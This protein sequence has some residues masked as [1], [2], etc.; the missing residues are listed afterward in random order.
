MTTVAALA[1]SLRIRPD[2]PDTTNL[3]EAPVRFGTKAVV[4]I[5]RLKE[6]ELATNHELR[7][8]HKS[9][10]TISR[11]LHIEPITRFVVP[12][13]CRGWPGCVLLIGWVR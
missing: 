2:L 13:N 4:V 12:R 10:G 1:E 6:W 11:F 9:P 7:N 5:P 3:T 8:A